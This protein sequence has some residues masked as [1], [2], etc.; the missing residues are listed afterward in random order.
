MIDAVLPKGARVIIARGTYIG[1]TGE[2][3]GHL[4]TEKKHP[5]HCV[6]IGGCDVVP[7]SMEEL[8]ELK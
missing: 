7:C 8:D 5:I 1:K 3:I 4:E 2:V 6:W